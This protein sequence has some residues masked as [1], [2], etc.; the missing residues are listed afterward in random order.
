MEDL[1]APGGAA[2]SARYV[3]GRNKKR[4]QSLKKM[5]GMLFSH[6]LHHSVLQEYPNWEVATL[7]TRKEGYLLVTKS[8]N[9]C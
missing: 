2:A 8:V 3:R 1:Q 6:R 7:C 5:P 4:K 9:M